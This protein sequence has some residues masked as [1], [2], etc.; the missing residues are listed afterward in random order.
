M[1][2]RDASAAGAATEEI[3]RAAF[4]NKLD[5]GFPDF[6]LAD[7][8]DDDIKVSFANRLDD[9]PIFADVKDFF[10]AQTLRGLQ[11]VMAAVPPTLTRQP[12]FLAS[13]DKHEANRT[14]ADNQDILA[15]AQI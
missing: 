13:G 8:F 14:R 15:G 5:G 2:S 12:K 9:I 3:D 11:A 10:R 7:G 1:S 4:A 6:R